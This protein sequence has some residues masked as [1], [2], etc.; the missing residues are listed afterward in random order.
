MG[1]LKIALAIVP[2]GIGLCVCA[3]GSTRM[4]AGSIVAEPSAASYYVLE[5][6]FSLYDPARPGLRKPFVVSMAMSRN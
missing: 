3:V 2:V 5:D 1:H 6:Y 4:S